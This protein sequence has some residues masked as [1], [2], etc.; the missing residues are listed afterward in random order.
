MTEIDLWMVILLF[1]VG[2]LVVVSIGI[3]LA[4]IVTLREAE[5]QLRRLSRGPEVTRDANGRPFRERL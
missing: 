1:A 5:R 4:A 2:G 3:V